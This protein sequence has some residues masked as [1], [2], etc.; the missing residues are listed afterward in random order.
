VAAVANFK[1]SNAKKVK[2]KLMT[3]RHVLNFRVAGNQAD[4]RIGLSLLGV[5]QL[6]A[7]RFLV[8]VDN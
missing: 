8:P 2:T 4:L 6:V 7:H 5:L 3:Y 1:F